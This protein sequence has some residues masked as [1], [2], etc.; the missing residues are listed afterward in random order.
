MRRAAP[1]LALAGV[2]AATGLAI[3]SSGSRGPT[4]ERPLVLAA[5]SLAEVLPQV[6][7]NAR[8]SFGGSDQLAQQI[9]MG[10]PADVFLSA[11]PRY[12]RSLYRER[13]VER[14][15]ALA[16]NTLVL[17]VPR[18]NPAGIRT[19]ADL[20]RSGVRLV[21]A[22]ENVP[23]GAYSLTVLRRL[24]LQRAL[25][26]VV[27]REPDV[28]GVVAKVALGE[29]D[30]G[31]VY[32]TDVR[33]VASQVKAIPLPARARPVARYEAA[34]VSSSRHRAAARA[35]LAELL[36]PTGRARLQAAGFGMP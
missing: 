7:G 36:G 11:S 30:A 27:S 31:F 23:A 20:A 22:G 17:L 3:A 13:L 32:A 33:P 14:P 29:A 1:L 28:K 15:V 19:V 26:N 35:F 2:V 5:A 25:G 10:A 12:T 6:D 34:L 4:P 8:Y 9:R 16:T 24:G 21:I 18:A